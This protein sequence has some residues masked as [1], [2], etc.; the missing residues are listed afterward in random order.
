MSEKQGS[1]RQ[2]I[3]RKRRYWIMQIKV[4]FIAGEYA[5][6][7]LSAICSRKSALSQRAGKSVAPPTHAPK[8]GHLSVSLS[9]GVQTTGGRDA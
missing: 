9:G 7:N 3:R 6:A 1:V 4:L 5:N 8:S 2:F